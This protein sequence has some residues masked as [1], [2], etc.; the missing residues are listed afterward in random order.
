MLLSHGYVKA[1]KISLDIVEYAINSVHPY[2][3]TKKIVRRNHSLLRVGSKLRFDIKKIENIY[4][5][6]AGKASLAIAQALEE[7]L[8]EKITRG[9]MIVKRGQKGSLSHIRVIEA[10]H[11]IPDEA[12]NRGAMKVMEL[13]QEAS[14]RDLV[15]SAITGGSSALMPLPADGI[16]LDDKKKLNKLLLNSGAT[17]HEI[18]AVRK[19]VSKI[20]G[21]RLAKA[22]YPA[23]LVNLTVSDVVDDALDYITDPTV[24]DTSTIEDARNVIRKHGLWNKL[25]TSV[26]KHLSKSNSSIETPK[27]L[28]DM[29]LH[30]FVLANN[31][32]ACT[33]AYRRAKKI[34]LNALV[35]S[36][37]IEGESREI[38]ILHTGIAKE[39]EKNGIPL[40]P[41]CVLI[42]GGETTV[43]IEGT[44]GRG[45]PSQECALGFAQK[46]TKENKIC[47]CAVDTDGS[48]GPTEAAG[49][50]IDGTTRARAEK[51]GINIHDALKR[52]DC[53]SALKKMRDLV[54]TGPTGTNV[55]DLRVIVVAV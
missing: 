46:L 24:S 40:Q 33:A 22:V 27:D 43:R 7:I 23:T 37:T 36:S 50:L 11:P 12:G 44:A 29:K 3:L 15:F 25:P 14:E 52:H 21:G 42:S 47:M 53:F 1:R 31:S 54:F 10:S 45:G 19:H 5:L 32:A 55:M 9:I 17:I 18:N 26:K 34:G 39:C 13:A 2:R 35:L 48:D 20:K 6:G 8:G 30:T 38:G 4:V 28:G 51:Q 16:S 49:A 41:P